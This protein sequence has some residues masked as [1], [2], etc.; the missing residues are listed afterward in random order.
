MFWV[1]KRTVSLRRY[2]WV[3]QHMF[4][5]RNKKINF[6][7]HTLF[8]RLDRD[9]ESFLSSLHSGGKSS[10][11][12]SLADFFFFKNQL[13]KN[14][15]SINLIPVSCLLWSSHQGHAEKSWG[16]SSVR[17]LLPLLHFILQEAGAPKCF[18]LISFFASRHKPFS[19]QGQPDLGPVIC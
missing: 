1:L 12:L 16:L 13:F 17:N 8:K 10:F 3:P 4:C 9:A 5:F 6:S 14:Y 2:F 11:F 19:W 15:I 7:L 18:L